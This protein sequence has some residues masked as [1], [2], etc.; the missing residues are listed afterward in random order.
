MTEMVLL[1]QSSTIRTEAPAHAAVGPGDGVA[2]A[3]AQLSPPFGG[4]VR[5]RASAAP[6]AAPEFGSTM[7]EDSSTASKL[8]PFDLA[9]HVQVVVVP[10]AVG[11]AAQVPGRSVVGD[12]RPVAA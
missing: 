4:H 11:R 8:D 1:F 2:D 3:A 7:S 9:E 6:C 12:D 5:E 10:A